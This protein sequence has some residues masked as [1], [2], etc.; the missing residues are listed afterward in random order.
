VIFISI[1]NGNI[2]FLFGSDV[3][4]YM[5]ELAQKMSK[6]SVIRQLTIANN[7]VVPPNNID[8]AFELE[9][10]IYTAAIEG[11]RNTFSPYLNF[12]EWR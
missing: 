8:E 12:R 10:W 11:I 5:K 2:A 1:I 4:A 9:S 7:K 3:E 6:L